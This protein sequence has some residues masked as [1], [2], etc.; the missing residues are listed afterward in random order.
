[1]G[2]ALTCIRSMIHHNKRQEDKID[3][4]SSTDIDSDLRVFAGVCV[5]SLLTGISTLSYILYVAF[6]RRY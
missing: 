2:A 4:C 1:M 6:I 3:D 5:L